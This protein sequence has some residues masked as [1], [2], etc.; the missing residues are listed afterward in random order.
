MVQNLQ[1]QCENFHCHQRAT[2]DG[3]THHSHES[4]EAQLTLRMFLAASGSS[5]VVFLWVVWMLLPPGDLLRG[6]LMCLTVYVTWVQ[7]SCVQPE[8][9]P[10]E[11][12][13]EFRIT[14]DFFLSKMT[15]M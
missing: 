2:S 14:S 4:K 11:L 9:L 1:C 15:R 10:N 5:E 8:C 7:M 3:H 6:M 13:L 12:M